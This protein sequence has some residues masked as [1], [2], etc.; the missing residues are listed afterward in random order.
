VKPFKLK[1]LPHRTGKTN[2]GEKVDDEKKVAFNI[3]SATSIENDV[4]TNQISWYLGSGASGPYAA[5]FVT[6][7]FIFSTFHQSFCSMKKLK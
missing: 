2:H 6:F 3:H 7:H 1:Y 4:S 5:D